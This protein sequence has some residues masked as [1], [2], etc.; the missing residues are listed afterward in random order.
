[1]SF[2]SLV[3]DFSESLF[4]RQCQVKDSNQLIPEFGGILDLMDSF[5]FAAPVSY[6]LF[7]WM[8]MASSPF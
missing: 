6:F 4:K 1:L 2:F 3:G 5:L 7:V 8:G